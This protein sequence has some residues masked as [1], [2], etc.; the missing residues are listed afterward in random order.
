MRGPQH[1]TG[2]RLRAELRGR[3]DAGDKAGDDSQP[4]DEPV[5]GQH[6]A[7]REKEQASRRAG[8]VLGP[9]IHMPQIVTF[10][11]RSADTRRN[12]GQFTL[13]AAGPQQR[14][15]NLRPLAR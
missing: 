6:S 2:G 13:P 14:A 7:I 12:S 8:P 5:Y 4:R 3:L 11:V 9:K 1:Y 15:E 10:K